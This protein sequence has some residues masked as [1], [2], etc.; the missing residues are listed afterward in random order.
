VPIL[1]GSR[2]HI[3]FHE[4]GHIE[5]AYLFGATV[6]GA[7][8]DVSG[9]P[10]T[11]IVHKPDLST[12]DPVACGGYAAEKI[13]FSLS[14]LV[15]LR[16]NPLT[17]GAFHMQA[18]QNARL[19]K[20]PFYI[21]EQFDHAL[22]LYPGSPFQPVGGSWPEESHVPFI[23]YA[24]QHVIPVL[25]GRLRF[26]EALAFELD[27]SGVLSHSDIETIRFGAGGRNDT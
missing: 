5:A 2:R 15:D 13:L 6:R 10:R 19:D 25:K 16:G 14:R 17:D 24:K 3:C 22:G 26:L 21:K 4:A 20:F 12:K 8:V 11:S 27:T 18:M 9:D 23:A 7:A 1:V